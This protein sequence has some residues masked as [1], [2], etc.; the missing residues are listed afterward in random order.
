MVIV[1]IVNK[2][3]MMK[4]VLWI[5]LFVMVMLSTVMVYAATTLTVQYTEPSVNQAGNPLTNL[6]E[7]TIYYKQDAGVEQVVKVPASKP[8]GGGAISRV[9][10]VNDPALCA[11]TTITVQASAS[12]TN[13]T[14]FESPR[15]GA[16]SATKNAVVAGCTVPN[17]PSGL[18]IT[19]Q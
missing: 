10:T 11:T 4:K 16:V 8:A 7:T 13:T 6:K 15:T 12:N 17:G 18:V 5:G 2:E 9:I 1:H 3:G 19:I 14:G